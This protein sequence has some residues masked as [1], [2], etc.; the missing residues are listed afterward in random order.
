MLARTSDTER[1]TAACRAPSVLW[2]LRSRI[3]HHRAAQRGHVG[4]CA[5]QAEE[6]TDKR[7]DRY[8]GGNG[9]TRYDACDIRMIDSGAE[10]ERGPISYRSKR[11]HVEGEPSAR[12]GARLA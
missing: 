11:E 10:G 3:G 9:H 12:R 7:E 2:T 1:R 4:T 6:Q 5:V 8:N